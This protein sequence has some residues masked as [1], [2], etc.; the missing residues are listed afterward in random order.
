MRIPIELDVHRVLLHRSHHTFKHER[1]VAAKL[2]FDVL[3]RE[4]ELG[5]GH[6]YRV[7]LL[8]VFVGNAHHS[9]SRRATICRFELLNHQPLRV[10]TAEGDETGAVNAERG[11]LV[12]LGFVFLVR[13]FLQCVCVRS[14]KSVETVSSVR[15]A[16]SCTT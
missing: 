14:M 6:N 16:T 12:L 3:L 1:T 15:S 7:V 2:V 4:V 5:D 11:F 10:R 8:D 13:F 9:C